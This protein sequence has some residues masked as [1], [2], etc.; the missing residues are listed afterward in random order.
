MERAQTGRD[1]QGGSC[2]VLPGNAQTQKGTGCSV[3]GKVS[4][5][6]TECQPQESHSNSTCCI[7]K[8]D[9]HCPIVFTG[10]KACFILGIQTITGFYPY[11]IPVLLINS[12]CRYIYAKHPRLFSSSTVRLNFT[13]VKTVVFSPECPSIWSPVHS[14]FKGQGWDRMTNLNEHGET[15]V[16]GRSHL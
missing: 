3:I 9:K 16:H 15:M 6:H 13:P 4:L 7:F 5:T 8:E 14:E 2:W 10:H 11:Q 12:S 1:H